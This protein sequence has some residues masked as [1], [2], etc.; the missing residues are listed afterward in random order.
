MICFPTQPP[1]NPLR[2]ASNYRDYFGDP[3]AKLTALT[4]Q[5][6]NASC[7][8]PRIYHA[9]DTSTENAGVTEDGYCEYVL[10]LPAG[11]FILAF[12]HSF[13]SL[14]SANTT[15]PP[16]GSGFRCQITDV[17]ADYKFFNKPVPEAYF[18][19]DVPSA[20]PTAPLNVTS[21]YVLNQTPRLL[22]GP[23]PVVPPGMF[24]VE[25]WNLLNSTND[26]IRLSLLVGIP[27]V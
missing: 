25:F 3:H 11:S 1:L 22:P 20:N 21:L 2:L 7:Y 27:D 4:D 16:V 18:L 6:C 24:K 26:L 12:M 9:P 5:I 19:N 17:K 23:Y 14:G 10:T 13:T 8:I 15:D